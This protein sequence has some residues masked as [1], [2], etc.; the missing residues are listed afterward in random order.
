MKKLFTAACILFIL[1]ET[2]LFAGENAGQEQP[3]NEKKDFFLSDIL[4]TY[5]DNLSF[6]AVTGLMTVES[7]FVPF[8]SE[9]VVPPAA[10]GACCPD[11]ENLYVTDSP[12]LNTVL[13]VLAA[14]AGAVLGALINYYLAMYLG[15]PVIYRLADSRAGRM[16]LLSPEKIRK[17]EEYFDRKGNISTFIGRLI[18]G[19]RQLISIPAG[20]ARMK[21]TSFVFFTALG[22]MI[23]N[24]VLAAMGYIAGGNQELINE[25][26]EILSWA[27]IGV[28]CAAVLIFILIKIKE[29]SRK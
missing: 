8:P 6:S 18:P 22:A 11:N 3:V 15:R 29:K 7:S 23:W 12:L 2:C 27:I 13:V 14:T 10:Y 17:A 21:M 9:I 19:I 1:T 20:L 24:T 26:S 25:Y 4:G 28:F 5:T 16:L